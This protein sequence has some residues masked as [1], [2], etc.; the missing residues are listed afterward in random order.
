MRFL[1]AVLAAAAT[2]C[3]GEP[4]SD[5]TLNLSVSWLEGQDR[6]LGQDLDA[7]LVLIPPDGAAE[8]RFLGTADAGGSLELGE[9]GPLV[10]GTRVGVLLEE[11]GGP[12]EEWTPEATVAYGQA[13]L[14]R[15]LALGEEAAEL[16]VLMALYG[17]V[18]L[19]GPL[20]AAK[21]RMAAAA[22]VVPGALYLFGG[23][24]PTTVYDE[25]GSASSNKIMK[26][27][28]LNGGNR[29]FEQIETTIPVSTPT[30]GV[31]SD[32]R[33]G[34]TAT[35]VMVDGNP[36]I[37]VAGGRSNWN[38]T[39]AHHDLWFLFD[40]ATDT[41][42]DQGKTPSAHS[43]HL[44]IPLR[45]D[46]VLLFGGWNI[47]SL[48]PIT[49]FDIW[50]AATGRA[51]AGEAAAI[52]VQ[53]LR[54]FGSSLEGDAV[55]CGGLSISAI[56]NRATG[57]PVADCS[58]IES[59]GEVEAFE[60]L[61]VPLA[62][63][64]MAE[65]PGGGLLVTGGYS[66]P[67]V[68]DFNATAPLFEVNQTSAAMWRYLPASG[69]KGVGEMGHPRGGHRMLPLPDGRVLIVGGA[70]QVGGLY[71]D[72]LDPVRCPE[73]YDP[74]DDSLR[75]VDCIDASQGAWP[76]VGAFPGE[77][78][79]VVEGFFAEPGR[80]VYEGGSAVGLIGLGPPLTP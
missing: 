65:L 4:A 67:V 73:L 23:G 75:E 50:S 58:K 11:P 48:V 14:D 10:A 71:G 55:V 79:M 30:D 60:D 44:A 31:D 8:I 61:P 66:D 21:R 69:W 19:E 57:T 5:Y 28:D 51:T 20:A 32:K 47:D 52:G 70:G 68:D 63:A 3:A 45:D 35:T 56:G 24:V 37:L 17:Q 49:S 7:K 12:Q 29:V 54:S 9:L 2:G 76:L 72:P 13:V 15:D 39:F 43:E 25:D 1:P 16:P 80:A 6:V 62:A 22:A 78:A 27:A 18:G 53:P 40:P 41:I 74:S 64:A 42:V 59:T 34:L 36:M 38:G 46:K 77:G 33:A 26:L